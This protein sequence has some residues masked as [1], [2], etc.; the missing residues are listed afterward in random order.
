MG[1]QFAVIFDIITVAVIVIMLFA[2]T[3]KGFVSTIIG[4]AS[5]VVAF[6]CA[7]L[8]SPVLSDMC[9]ESFVEKPIS[10][11][12]SETLDDSMGNLSLAGAS[13]MDFDK[14]R[15]SGT[16][17]TEITPDYGGTDKALFDLSSVDF[18]DTGFEKL[19]LEKFGFD[20]SED[21]SK[22]DGKNA[23]FTMSDMETYG[24]GKLVTAQIIA[25]KLQGTSVLHEITGYTGKIGKAVPAVFGSISQSIDNGELS[26]LRTLVLHMVDAS[27]SVKTAVIDG[28]IK[29]VFI[30]TAKTVFFIIIFAAVSL[31]LGVLAYVT[32]FVNKIP[33]VGDLNEFLGA[34]AGLV[35]GLLT[36]FVV[37]I[38]TRLI[39]NLSGGV[40]LF[41][42]T[43]I[44]QTYIFRIFYNF[45]FLNFL[46]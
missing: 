29:P 45:E 28:M 32:K 7:M 16:L 43:A 1:T 27:A 46:T 24:L 6:I 25:V 30:I 5:A 40:L 23:E 14:I 11:A 21:F 34:I 12:V 39:V 17:V 38:V 9:Y 44:E 33:L 41:N 31:I 37:C 20:G 36:V 10:E 8:F 18:T 26:A 13:E 42:E 22:L 19:P 4:M 15:I 3:H 2:G 35:Q